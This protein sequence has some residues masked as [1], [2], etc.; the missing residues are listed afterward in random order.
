MRKASGV[1]RRPQ[2]RGPE[3]GEGSA[4]LGLS[5]NPQAAGR[6][7][8]S[9]ALR[10]Q[11]LTRGAGADPVVGDG[12]GMLDTGDTSGGTSPQGAETTV[13]SGGG[14]GSGGSAAASTAT[15]STADGGAAGTPAG[16]AVVPHPSPAPSATPGWL[17]NARGLGMFSS[18]DA[19]RRTPATGAAALT[20]APS[21][22]RHTLRLR[23]LRTRGMP[24][25]GP[26][27]LEGLV[28]G[29][30]TGPSSDT[31]WTGNPL[32]AAATATGTGRQGAGTTGTAQSPMRGDPM[33]PG[34]RV[35]GGPRVGV[36]MGV[37]AEGGPE[38]PYPV[39][40]TL[41]PFL[42]RGGGQHALP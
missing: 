28:R 24:V 27:Q 15:V 9:I 39:Q 17:V 34:S 42:G 14:G 13:A 21:A 33:S 26:G 20:A 18:W 22:S 38:K 40:W 11:H 10:F 35:A 30:S 19:H 6:R 32:L 16:A 36:P 2:A 25:P 23:P 3:A 29:A 7:R 31:V 37:V 8:A 4:D 1:R 41:N 12:L 5:G